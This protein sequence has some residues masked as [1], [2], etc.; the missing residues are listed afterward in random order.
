MP[1]MLL[2]TTCFVVLYSLLCLS[3]ALH[4]SSA[5]L[6][7]LIR[8]VQDTLKKPKL[9]AHFYRCGAPFTCLGQQYHTNPF[10]SFH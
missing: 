4:V 8:L 5:D 3:G 9:Q 1:I 2:E 10:N 7:L 6:W